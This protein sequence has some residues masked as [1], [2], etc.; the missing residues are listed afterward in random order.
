MV[1]VKGNKSGSKP[2]GLQSY[3]D[4]DLN[5]DG[6]K[7]VTVEGAVKG[8][9]GRNYEFVMRPFIRT[10]AGAYELREAP[11]SLQGSKAGERLYAFT[12]EDPKARFFRDGLM[13]FAVGQRAMI[14]GS[15]PVGAKKI[16]SIS[17]ITVKISWTL[18][19]LPGL[20]RFCPEMGRGFN[21]KHQAYEAIG[22]KVGPLVNTQDLSWVVS[23]GKNAADVERF[24]IDGVT[25]KR[26]PDSMLT[27]SELLI[28]PYFLQLGKMD[29]KQVGGMTLKAKKA[30]VEAAFASWFA[31][32]QTQDADR[33]NAIMN[34]AH[35]HN[36]LLKAGALLVDLSPFE[37]D[38]K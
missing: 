8:S 31:Q 5:R 22:G 10:L 21:I 38:R 29:P 9:K 24:H 23:L 26:V 11:A 4:H 15:Q 14:R 33:A 17:G 28:R 2:L 19:P 18:L 12:D 36:G 7:D 3:E 16:I 35:L 37:M 34:D 30:A 27:K 6:V 32:A 25:D 20:V 1:C 13:S